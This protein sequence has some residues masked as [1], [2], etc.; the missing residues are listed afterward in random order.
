MDCIWHSR[1][2]TRLTDDIIIEKFN[3]AQLTR[4]QAM[5]HAAFDDLM[6]LLYHKSCKYLSHDDAMDVVLDAAKQLWA[7]VRRQYGAGGATL[8]RWLEDV[9]VHG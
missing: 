8:D 4:D 9:C 1:G 5:F 2:L 7:W 3:Q 6:H